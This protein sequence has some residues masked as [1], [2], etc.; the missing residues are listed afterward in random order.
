MERIFKII[1]KR[2]IFRKREELLMIMRK[3]VNKKMKITMKRVK[4]TMALKENLVKRIIIE[5]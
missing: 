2:K 3:V 4:M 5:K 1:R